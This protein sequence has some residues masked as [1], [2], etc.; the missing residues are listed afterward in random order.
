MLNEIVFTWVTTAKGGAEQSTIAIGESIASTIG[1]KVSVLFLNLGNKSDFKNYKKANFNFHSLDTPTEYKKNLEKIIKKNSTAIVI[2]NHRAFE[3]DHEIAS[4]NGNKIG[5]VFRGILIED[6]SFRT[7]NAHGVFSHLQPRELNWK[8]INQFDFIIANSITTLNSIKP[9]SKRDVILLYNLIE[10]KKLKLIN[11]KTLERKNFLLCARLEKWKNI[12]FGILAFLKYQ[13]QQKKNNI[14]LNIVGDGSEMNSLKDMFKEQVKKGFI[15]FHGWKENLSHYYQEHK[16]LIVTSNYES[17]GRII[18][19]ANSH[20][21]PALV[22]SSGAAQELIFD[23]LN[24]LIY[25]KDN[26]ANFVEKLILYDEMNE[27]AKKRMSE[28][29]KIKSI[30]QFDSTNIALNFITQLI[31]NKNE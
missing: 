31:N 24:G 12:E 5:I 26:S 21:L 29:S 30:S 10:K 7:F 22:P 2:S 3:I 20:G 8:K 13:Q 9:Y 23:G 11:S 18:L 6:L 16:M 15:T 19:E 27:L 17:F 4:K 25:E 1:L 28:F 14:V